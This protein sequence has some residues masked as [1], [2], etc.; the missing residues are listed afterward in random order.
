MT[1]TGRRPTD[2]PLA[3]LL[4]ALESSGVPPQS[5]IDAWSAGG[6]EPANA[7]WRASRSANLRLALLAQIHHRDHAVAV[8]AA[9][10]APGA[11]ASDAVLARVPTIP[12][13]D[14]LLVQA[15]RLTGNAPLL[16][17]ARLARS[18]LAKRASI[19]CTCAADSAGSI[20]AI[21][22]T[23]LPIAAPAARVWSVSPG[24]SAEFDL[25]LAN[26]I[27]FVVDAFAA[28]GTRGEITVHYDEHH[29][30]I[31]VTPARRHWTIRVAVDTDALADLLEALNRGSA[32]PQAW[33]DAWS[34]VG[35]EP[36]NAAWRA[37]TS[38]VYR[39]VLLERLGHPAYAA[40]RDA[41]E[42]AAAA[43]RD[44]AEVDDVR[45]RRI[46]D[47]ALAIVP[48]IPSL[49]GVILR[50]LRMDDRAPDETELCAAP[51][52]PI[53]FACECTHESTGTLVLITR[54]MFGRDEDATR[55]RCVPPGQRTVVEFE[56]ATAEAFVLETV[57]ARGVRGHIV[58]RQ[59]GRTWHIPIE[60][61]PRRT[62][63]R[64][65]L[66]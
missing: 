43:S 4:G 24:G 10:A 64:V 37:S 50:A 31:P 23:A 52:P 46:A 61:G 48:A 5:W 47:A 27:A 56:P 39:L 2:D 59:G 3:A 6:A 20:A 14:A 51:S 45:G 8:A 62:A 11:A 57:A 17:E 53:V 19:A 7:A 30:T 58:A 42:R 44:A 32:P 22:R 15:A 54:T 41:V 21:V 1:A 9:S 66:A 33:I 49:E 12:P 26:E 25:D 35:T 36:A 13:L 16:V 55:V 34:D 28:I 18:A 29:K 63:I 65:V 38:G 40:A 60:L